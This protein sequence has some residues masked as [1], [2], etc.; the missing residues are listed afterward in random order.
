M[1]QTTFSGPVASQNGFYTGVFTTAERDA[2]TNVAVGTLI[3]NSD[4]GVYDVY[5]NLSG[6]GWTTAFGPGPTPP[7]SFPVTL[8][9]LQQTG[10]FTDTAFTFTPDGTKVVW[11]NGSYLQERPLTTP[12]DITTASLFVTQTDIATI[13]G[14]SGM[15]MMRPSVAFSPD[16]MALYVYYINQMMGT[17]YTGKINLNVAYDTT[18]AV[19]FETGTQLNGLQSLY[20]A[21]VTFSADGTKAYICAAGWVNQYNLSTPYGWLNAP[22]DASAQ[23]FIA[24]LFNL[25]NYPQQFRTNSD[26]TIGFVYQSGQSY[27]GEITQFQ[28]STPFDINTINGNTFVTTTAGNGIGY[29]GFGGIDVRP[30]TSS[31]YITGM[32]ASMM[33]VIGEQF[34]I[35]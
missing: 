27:Q 34:T 3:F 2:L 19:Y 6:G 5:T 35:S 33:Y 32:D 16:G 9:Y 24:G 14:F 23:V 30:N 4:T 29:V 10:N 15:Y 22:S 26:G 8:T 20:N 13:M 31:L 11:A 21:G 25:Y 18:T 28:M 1:S 12:W 7:V 17:G